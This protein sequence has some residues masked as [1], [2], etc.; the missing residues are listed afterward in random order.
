MK[1]KALR[2]GYYKRYRNKG[3]EFAW[4]E[5]SEIPSWCEP[6]EVPAKVEKPAKVSKPKEE[7]SEEE[8]EL[9]EKAKELGYKNWYNAGLKKVKAFIEKSETSDE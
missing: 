5:D 7:K 9:R 1:V 6:A 3:D 8:V 4:A 2:D